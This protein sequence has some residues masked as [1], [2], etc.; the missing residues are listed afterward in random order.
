MPAEVS[1]PDNMSD[2]ERV[3]IDLQLDYDVID[4][5]DTVETLLEAYPDARGDELAVGNARARLRTVL[6]YLVANH[7]NRLVLGTGNRT[8]FLTGYLT[9]HG[10][11]AVDCLPIGYLYKQQVRQL[12]RYVGVPEDIVEKPATAGLWPGQTDEDELGLS[13]DVLDAILALRVD[14]P[15][16]SVLS[17]HSVEPPE[18]ILLL[19]TDNPLTVG[20]TAEL[21]GVDKE[22]V[23]QV[24]R[25][26]EAS[27]HKRA[28]PPTPDVPY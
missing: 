6:N 27:K 22:V 16:T 18:M 9:K 15:N 17:F 8:E 26:Y 25:R 20:Q 3:A 1:Q 19:E 5:S 11:G 4:I 7:E 24:H 12:A 21:V 10:D 13:Y 23:R 28:P 2:A 14:G